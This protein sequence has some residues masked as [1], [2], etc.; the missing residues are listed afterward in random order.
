MSNL[1]RRSLVASALSALAVPAVA[2]FGL[3]DA[4]PALA[5]DHICTHEE[6]AAFEFE[7]MPQYAVVDGVPGTP[8]FREA[9][10]GNLRCVGTGTRLAFVTLGKTKQEL[11]EITQGLL[12]DDKEDVAFEL[13]ESLTTVRKLTEE[14][15]GVL[16]SAEVRT[17]CAMTNCCEAVQS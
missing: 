3:S 12:D 15:V 10:E 17:L 6:L 14:L 16:K 9:L 2:T 4:A 7:A 11:I 8:A 13:I 5:D 1:S